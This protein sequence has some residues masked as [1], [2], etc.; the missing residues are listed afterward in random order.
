MYRD[1]CEPAREKRDGECGPGGEL[2]RLAAL[3]DR[4]RPRHGRDDRRR[5]RH[6][7]REHREPESGVGAGLL[8]VRHIR[9]LPAAHL[10]VRIN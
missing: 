6:E 4:E 5:H 10:S 1:E 9:A 7:P 2:E 3:V 8:I